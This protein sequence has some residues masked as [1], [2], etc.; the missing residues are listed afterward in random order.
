MSKQVQVK[1]IA[2]EDTYGVVLKKKLASEGRGF[3]RGCSCLLWLC[4]VSQP[5]QPLLDAHTHTLEEK[6]ETHRHRYSPFTT[7]QTQLSS[8]HL[9]LSRPNVCPF[10]PPE[11]SESSISLLIPLFIMLFYARSFAE[12]VSISSLA[13]HSN[14]ATDSLH[15]AGDSIGCQWQQKRGGN[16]IRPAISFDVN[17]IVNN[18]ESTR[19]G[20]SHRGNIYMLPVNPLMGL[21]EPHSKRNTSAGVTWSASSRARILIGRWPA[22]LSPLKICSLDER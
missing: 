15:R 14:T 3:P 16:G 7:I 4:C 5:P 22:C 17:F 13:P 20:P 8:W 11:W 18:Y 2:E 19:E 10:L 1:C 6:R 21:I 12:S 9:H